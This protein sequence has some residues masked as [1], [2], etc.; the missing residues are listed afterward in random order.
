MLQIRTEENDAVLFCVEYHRY[1]DVCVRNKLHRV[2][3]RPILYGLWT[4]RLSPSCIR[5]RYH[6]H[7]AL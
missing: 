5:T 1:G 6:L 4:C 3:H 7:I 2:R